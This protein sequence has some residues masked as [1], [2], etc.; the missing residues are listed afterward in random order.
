VV[1]V[2]PSRSRMPLRTHSSTIL[3]EVNRDYDLGNVLGSGHFG[4]VR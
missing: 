1:G 4:V 2:E 3:K